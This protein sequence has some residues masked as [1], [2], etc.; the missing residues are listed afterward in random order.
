MTP[1]EL[2]VRV[3]RKIKVLGANETASAEDLAVATQSVLDAHNA[4]E[5]QRLT[6]WTLQDIPRQV[7]LGYVL[8]AAYLA[9]DEFV[10]PK[11]PEWMGQGL[12]TVQAFVHIPLE[13]DITYGQDF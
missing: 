1:A 10:V 5:V 2:A 9:A 7:E 12:R 3:L 13:R 8:M 4:L 6:R 11:E